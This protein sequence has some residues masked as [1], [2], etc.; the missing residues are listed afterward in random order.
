ME[1]LKVIRHRS[2]YITSGR[3]DIVSSLFSNCSSLLSGGAI[4]VG[5]DHYLNINS[6]T[7]LSC[8]SNETGGS[9]YTAAKTK[10]KC[11]IIANSVAYRI[12]E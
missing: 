2:S 11:T 6:C 8:E 9:I 5:V 3:L 12:K 10:I 1:V 7:F 4:S